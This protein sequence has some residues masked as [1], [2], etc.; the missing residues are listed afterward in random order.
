MLG[1]DLGSRRIGLAASDRSGTLASPLSV[2]ERGD[3]PDQDRRA[4]VDAARA[5]GARR[6]VVGLP[7]GLSGRVGPA[8]RAALDEIAAIRALAGDDLPVDTYD[9]RFTSVIA[10]RG[11]M[12]SRGR[13]RARRGT[14]DAAAAAVMLQSWLEARR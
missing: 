8:A 10:E 4:V 3:D 9:E 6:I 12:E 7:V 1:V 11:L 2:L 5:I 14:V 13:R